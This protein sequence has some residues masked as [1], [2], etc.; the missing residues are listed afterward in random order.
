MSTFHYIM[1]IESFDVFILTA[2]KVK[3]PSKKP[4]TRLSVAQFPIAILCCYAHN[5]LT[6]S[7]PH[8]KAFICN[9]DQSLIDIFDYIV[10]I[11]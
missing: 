9:H 5:S 4:S 3:S 6:D 10:K 1:G 8:D 2:H 7:T 11:T